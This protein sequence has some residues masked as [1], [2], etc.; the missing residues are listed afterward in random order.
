M[1]SL[2]EEEQREKVHEVLRGKHS[3]PSS[4]HS[5]DA[6][7]HLILQMKIGKKDVMT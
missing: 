4:G 2:V 6:S 7:S 1:E 5:Q 3:P